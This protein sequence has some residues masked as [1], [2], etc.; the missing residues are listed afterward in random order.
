MKR[1]V[2]VAALVGVTGC[3]TGSAVYRKPKEVPLGMLIGGTV[4]DFVVTSLLV[5]GVTDYTVGA[6]LATGAGVMG[7]D[8]AVGCIFF[9]ACSSL[10]P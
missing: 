6:S 2:V 10:R 3:V 9:N 1:L 7:A 8:V 4:A 5:S